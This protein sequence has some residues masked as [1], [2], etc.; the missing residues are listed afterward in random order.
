M[1][2]NLSQL[3]DLEQFTEILNKNVLQDNQKTLEKIAQPDVLE[4]IA[5]G[6]TYHEICVLYFM[7][8]K[9]KQY[10]PYASKALTTLSSARPDAPEWT[11]PMLDSYINS[12][13]SL[14]AAVKGNLIGLLRVIRDYDKLIDKY[15]ATSYHPEFLQGSLLENLP[16]VFGAHSKAKQR[17]ENIVTKYN[18]D[19]AYATPKII[20][21]CYLSLGKLSK[22]PKEKIDYLEQSI[23]IDS[24]GDGGSTLAKKI[25][26]TIHEPKS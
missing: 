15:S 20:S 22:N 24:S 11:L 8:E 10:A 3:K 16:N 12:S 5:L 9:N 14:V 2:N 7:L 13:R 25:L 6:L 23:K 17:F 19:H 26:G 18:K 21:F 4:I 1:N